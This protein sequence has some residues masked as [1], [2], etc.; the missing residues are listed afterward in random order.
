MPRRPW[1]PRLE[2]RTARLKLPVRK[3]PHDFVSIAPGIQLG[4]RRCK[5][6]G[7]WVVKVA[8]GHGRY[9]TKRVGYADDHEAADG[10]HIL[11]WWAA[12]DKARALARGK[13][14]AG[15][16]PA[17][18]A[19]ALTDYERD[20]EKRGGDKVNASRARFHLTPALLSKPVGLLTARELRRWRDGLALKPATLN[21]TLR[22]VK[23]ALNFAVA[24]DPRIAN[25]E[26]WRIG[27]GALSDSFNA[28]NTILSDAEVRAIVAA[29]YAIDPAF[30]LY[31][32]AAA[33]V[34]ARPSQ[35]ARLEVGDL[36]ADRDDPRLM[37]PSSRKGRGRRY[38]VR[39]PVP[40][41]ADLAAKL[42][43]AAGNRALTAPLLLRTD[44]ERWQPAKSDHLRLFAQAAESAGLACTM[45][46]LRHSS[47]VRS[48]LAGTPVRVTA[49]A[50]DTGVLMLERVYSQYILDHS[51][52]VARRGLLN[53]SQSGNVVTIARGRR[54]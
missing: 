42:R 51:D 32:E 38:V 28:R 19:E 8:D 31:V 35:L 3:K 20:L 13:D 17:T 39:K 6:A 40:I 9:W 7:R 18:L 25:R 49:A 44:G 41:T 26:A 21:R 16:R 23:A 47:I 15:G 53:I 24:T 50:H 11:D 4:Y 34:G 52:V 27:L 14:A 33:V 12:Q 2:T 30:G 5:G 45:Y 48:L 46:S 54:A 37:L 43:T 1:A 36:Q 22:A 29:A 10:E